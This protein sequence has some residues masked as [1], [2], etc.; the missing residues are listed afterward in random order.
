MIGT[1]VAQEHLK[2]AQARVLEVKKIQDHEA[3][4]EE[5]EEWQ[6]QNNDEYSADSMTLNLRNVE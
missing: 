5:N 2:L 3:I 6:Q 4:L 1:R